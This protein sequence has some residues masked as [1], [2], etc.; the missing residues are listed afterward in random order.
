MAL[1]GMINQILTNKWTLVQISQP[2]S[3]SRWK[4]TS[5][6]LELLGLYSCLHAGSNNGNS[7]P[8]V[9]P[10][11]S[12]VLLP[13]VNLVIVRKYVNS[14]DYLRRPP[15]YEFS[16][17]FPYFQISNTVQIKSYFSP[18]HEPLCILHWSH[19]IWWSNDNNSEGKHQGQGLVCGCLID[20]PELK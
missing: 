6:H 3:F 1:P 13:H 5:F 16:C 4:W 9:N 19:F 15:R 10:W 8:T 20:W 14:V 2:F 18:R 12:T 17:D 7:E 11:L